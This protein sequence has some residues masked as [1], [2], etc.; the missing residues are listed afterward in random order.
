MTVNKTYK[1]AAF[2][3]NIILAIF[4][5]LILLT[6]L[7]VNIGW[8]LLGLVFI[9]LYLYFANRSDMHIFILTEDKLIVKNRWRPKFK[10][11][12]SYDKMKSAAYGVLLTN[13]YIHIE[14]T[15][16]KTF[17]F[18][19]RS[20]GYKDANELVEDLKKRINAV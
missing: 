7:S 13:P 2:G 15:E 3:T 1:G 16:T 9:N 20:I 14:T 11:E 12:I 10:E 8:Y 18:G 4:A 19:C 5:N 17:T 6:M